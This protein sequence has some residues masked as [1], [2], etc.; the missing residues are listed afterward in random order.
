[1]SVRDLVLLIGEIAENTAPEKLSEKA[2]AE[3]AGT[4]GAAALDHGLSAQ[5]WEGIEKAY[6]GGFQCGYA[7][8]IADLTLSA[9]LKLKP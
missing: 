8:A 7:A 9:A 2:A 6:V 4:F 1:M 3:F 5:E